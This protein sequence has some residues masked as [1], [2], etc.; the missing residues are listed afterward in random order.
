MTQVKK[1]E[2][3]NDFSSLCEFFS[4]LTGLPASP[5]GN[6][7]LKSSLISQI[8]VQQTSTSSIISVNGNCYKIVRLLGE[9][10]HSRVFAG[11][12]IRLNR[13]VAIKIV[14]NVDTT[15]RNEHSKMFFKEI[16]YLTKLQ[17]R[18]PYVVRV[19]DHEFDSNNRLGK[20]VMETGQDFRFLLPLQASPKEKQMNID[21]AKLYWY[22]MVDAVAS[23]HRYGIVHSG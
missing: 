16:R 13:S 9:G 23:L 12:D 17:T 7:P 1:V 8:N 14:Q 15:S 22:Q 3:K 11:F 19:F 6:V 18:N 21:R 10:L 2:T 5:T 4:F 20:I